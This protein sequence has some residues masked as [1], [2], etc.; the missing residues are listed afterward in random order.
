[1]TIGNTIELE[2]HLNLMVSGT[3]KIN[4]IFRSNIY[5]SFQESYR[6]R[7]DGTHHPSFCRHFGL[8]RLAGFLL[9]PEI[10]ENRTVKGSMDDGQ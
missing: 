10:Q 1:M 9:A 5:Y 8:L 7:T 2:I 6:C 3:L 4:N